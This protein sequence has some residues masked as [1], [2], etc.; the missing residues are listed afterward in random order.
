MQ[1]PK[2][3]K[4]EMSPIECTFTISKPAFR[5]QKKKKHQHSLRHM[6]IFSALWKLD[7]KDNIYILEI[8]MGYTVRSRLAWDSE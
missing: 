1:I 8:T 6:F 7:P 3:P 2:K 4:L 5:Y